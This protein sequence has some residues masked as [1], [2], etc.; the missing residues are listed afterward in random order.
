MS[1]GKH[2]LTL[3]VIVLT[4]I[5]L[6]FC[7]RGAKQIPASEMMQQRDYY[8][9]MHRLHPYDK[10]GITRPSMRTALLS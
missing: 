4:V 10:V 7:D 9:Q 8:E 2:V 6:F 5:A 1:K 3:A